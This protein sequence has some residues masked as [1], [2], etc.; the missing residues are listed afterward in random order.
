MQ[1]LPLTVWFSVEK[2]LTGH[3]FSPLLHMQLFRFPSLVSIEVLM[4]SHRSSKNA[5]PY[6]STKILLL[7]S[8]TQGLELLLS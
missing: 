4:R 8:Q 2:V 7:D 1:G 6:S 3:T 5:R